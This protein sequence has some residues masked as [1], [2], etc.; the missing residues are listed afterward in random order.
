MIAATS[1]LVTAYLDE[2]T[3]AEMLSDPH[4]VFSGVFAPFGMAR[5]TDGGYRVSG[6]WPFA[7]GVEHSSWRMGG[8]LVVDGDSSSV[9]ASGAPMIHQVVFRA[10]ET[11]VIDTWHVSGLCGTGSHDMIVEDVVVP[12]ERTFCLGIDR[13]RHSG[14]LYAVPTFGLLSV[15]I[16]AV[17][18][19]IAREAIESLVAL[20]TTKK[21]TGS[22]RSLAERE[23]TQLQVGRAEALLRA[24]RAF[25][26]TCGEQIYLKACNGAGIDL[27]DRAELRL[28]A[29]HAAATCAR[30][31][32]LMYEAGGG[33]SIYAK[34][35]L[36]RHFRDVHV[37]TQHATVARAMYGVAARGRLGLSV[38]TNT[39]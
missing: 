16:A 36:Q 27:E 28:A 20:A 33:T 14:P 23:L 38:D 26:V 19:G 6:R 37:I 5:A 15:A 29:T 9:S 18:L 3:A 22:R 1:A 13:P 31:V 12:R 24:A 39:L 25:L 10:D 32:D 8:V 4:A 30:V 17:S 21:P 7:S 34:H 2:P 35:P 11:R